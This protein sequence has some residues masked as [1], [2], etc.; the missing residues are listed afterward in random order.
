MTKFI[1][2]SYVNRSGSTYLINILSKKKGFFVCTEA[3]ILIDLFLKDPLNYSGNSIIFKRQFSHAITYD[4]QLKLWDLKRV[5]KKKIPKG[6]TNFEMLLNLLNSYKELFSPSSEY[7][8]FKSN[9]LIQVYNEHT[10]N[11]QKNIFYI[12]LIRDVRGIF[13][14]QRK[15]INPYT[16]KVLNKNPLITAYAW[17]NLINQTFIN[18]ECNNIFAIRYEDLIS[19]NEKS[20]QKLF[21]KFNIPWLTIE[22]NE[23]LWIENRIPLKEKNIHPHIKQ[24]PIPMK[25][26]SWEEELSISDLSILQKVTSTEL[27]QMRYVIYPIRKGKLKNIS[28]NY[29]FKLR[30][31]FKIDKY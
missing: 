27:K 20:L 11:N 10:L 22:P 7:I 26:N 16:K 28:K 9:N 14:S 4:E 8:V 25:I 6:Q 2:L 19:D 13:A 30:I 24:N 29:Y 1:F 3:N 23:K 17:K 12:S 18:T 5:Y 15:T 21:Y 31:L